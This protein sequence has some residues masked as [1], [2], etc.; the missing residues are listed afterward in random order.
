MTIRKHKKRVSVNTESNKK[1]EMGLLL[2]ISLRSISKSKI[3]IQMKRD[4]L[5]KNFSNKDT[6]SWYNVIYLQ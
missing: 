3:F 2:I 4:I 6:V 5:V 1:T